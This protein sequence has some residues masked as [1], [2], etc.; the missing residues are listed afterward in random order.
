MK[1]YTLRAAVHDAQVFNQLR[2]EYRRTR[3]NQRKRSPFGSLSRCLA[4]IRHFTLGA[5]SFARLR[6]RWQ[7]AVEILAIIILLR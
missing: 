1:L 3:K 6:R 5:R 2:R 4:G 7:H